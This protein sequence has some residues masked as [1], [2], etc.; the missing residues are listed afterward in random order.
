MTSHTS[1]IDLVEALR[2]LVPNGDDRQAASAVMNTVVERTLALTDELR[3][4]GSTYFETAPASSLHILE[5]NA[6]MSH[7]V[8][9][10]IEQWPR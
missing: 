9:E 6:A 5:L 2:P 10:W 3:T 1:R 7:A 8:L 4:V